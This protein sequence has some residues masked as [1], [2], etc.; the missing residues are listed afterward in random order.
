[1]VCPTPVVNSIR[2]KQNFILYRLQY[3]LRRDGNKG[4]TGQ[5]DNSCTGVCAGGKNKSISSGSF[6]FIHLKYLHKLKHKKKN[7]NVWQFY[8]HTCQFTNK[9]LV[10]LNLSLPV[11]SM[12]LWRIICRDKLRA[13]SLP[14]IRYKDVHSSRIIRRHCV[15]SCKIEADR[16]NERNNP[17]VTDLI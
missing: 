15:T 11:N 17:I 10:K 8:W 7:E 14:C 16:G 12:M 6:L 4:C 1:M 9:E 2:I 3:R 5:E 13:T